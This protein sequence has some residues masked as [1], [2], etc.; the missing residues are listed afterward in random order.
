METDKGREIDRDTDKETN[1]D[2][3]TQTRRQNERQTKNRRRDRQRQTGRQTKRHTDRHT[4][5]HT[6]RQRLQNFRSIII[7]D[8]IWKETCRDSCI[9]EKRPKGPEK[10][11]GHPEELS[12]RAKTE[13]GPYLTQ[14]YQ[15]EV[16]GIF[17]PAK[18][19][20]NPI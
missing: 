7:I 3:E 19:Q 20:D 15:L 18:K 9:L 1:R 12:A 17:E 4:H 11:R 6:Q 8:E 16:S 13:P 14:V 5:T 2:T 10:E